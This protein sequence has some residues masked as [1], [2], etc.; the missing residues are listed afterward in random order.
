MQTHSFKSHANLPPPIPPKGASFWLSFAAVLLCSFLGALDLSVISTSLPTIVSELHGDEDFVWVGSAYN[1]A[2]A[3]ILPFIGQLADIMG[4]RPLMMGSVGVF[5]IGSALAGSAKTINWLI[6]ARSTC[7]FNAYLCGGFSLNTNLSRSCTRSRRWWYPQPVVDY[8]LRPCPSIRTWSVPG[9]AYNG[10]LCCGDDWTTR[11]A[12][13]CRCR[14]YHIDKHS[15]G[16]ALSQDVSWRW[17]FCASA[18]HVHV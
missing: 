3:A 17:I 14:C 12:F 13:L 2:S 6:G 9:H 1:L 11:R 10:I 4:R 7:A 8:Y 16:A 5:F 18:S 15:Q